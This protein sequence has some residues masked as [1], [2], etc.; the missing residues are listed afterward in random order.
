M[1]DTENYTF[2]F[3]RALEVYWASD[4][5]GTIQAADMVRLFPGE[6][7]RHTTC[8]LPVAMAWAFPGRDVGDIL[9]ALW[10]VA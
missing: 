4:P 8:K 7:H 6:P 3:D 9:E 2:D 1:T 5:G 10:G